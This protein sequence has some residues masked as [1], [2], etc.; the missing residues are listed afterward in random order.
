MGAED[1]FMYHRFLVAFYNVGATI[2]NHHTLQKKGLPV[3]GRTPKK[4]E[5]HHL[6]QQFPPE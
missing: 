6:G 5:G 3:S 1:L 2:N 4:P